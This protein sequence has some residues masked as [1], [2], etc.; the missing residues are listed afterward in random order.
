MA[1]NWMDF[2][3]V[4]DPQIPGKWAF[5]TAGERVGGFATAKAARRAYEREKRQKNPLQPHGDQDV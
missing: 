4:P 1:I 5:E 3:I 2:R